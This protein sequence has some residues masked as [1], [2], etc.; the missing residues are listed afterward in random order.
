MTMSTTLCVE[1]P[2]DMAQSVMILFLFIL[3]LREPLCQT[4]LSDWSHD[5]YVPCLKRQSHARTVY[6]S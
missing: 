4:L 5:A 3:K 6:G 1:A 2:I